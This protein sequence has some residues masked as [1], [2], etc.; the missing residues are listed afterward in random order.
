[1]TKE[2]TNEQAK[3]NSHLQRLSDGL[4]R[5]QQPT[6]AVRRAWSD[7]SEQS[8]DA[9]SLSRSWSN[10]SSLDVSRPVVGKKFSQTWLL[11]FLLGA[12]VFFLLSVGISFYIVT[13]NRNVVSA[14]NVKLELQGSQLVRS[15]EQFNLQ[16]M[17]FNRN[18][19]DLEQVEVVVTYPTGTRR[20]D[21][22][23]KELLTD[24]QQIGALKSG[25]TISRVFPAVLVGEQNSQKE[26]K[27]TVKYH[28]PGSNAEF[29]KEDNYLLTISSS[30]LSLKMN[31]PDEVNAGSE[32]S[33]DIDIVSNAEATLKNLLLTI[34]YPPGF[35]FIEASTKAVA[36]NNLWQLGDLVPG[37][38]RHLSIKGYLA[39]QA[40]DLK[41]FRLQIGPAAIDDD[42]QLAVAYQ[43]AFEMT[44]IKK[45][46]LSISGLVNNQ[47]AEVVT[48]ADG[49]VR[50][51]LNW[52]NNTN[53]E[54][55]DAR[56][57]LTFTGQSLDPTSVKVT[58]AYYQSD[59]NLIYW[60]K[61][62]YPLLA[63]LTPGSSGSTEVEF[64]YRDQLSGKLL[65]NP[66]I[67]WQ[68]KLS[69]WRRPTGSSP[70]SFSSSIE[71]KIR[72]ISK[73]NLSSQVSYQGGVFQPSGP[74]P[75]RANQETTYTISYKLTNS[76]NNLKNVRLMG[77]L[78][79]GVKWLNQVSPVGANISYDDSDRLL[80]WAMD[81]VPA[82][83]GYL[84]E[85]ETV[86]FQ[87]ALTPSLS[88]VGSMANLIEALQFSA[89][90]SFTE[91][92]ISR[93]FGALTTDLR[94]AD[95]SSQ[96][97]GQVLE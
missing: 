78:P 29:K 65:L 45:S 54:I 69:A 67:V 71:K 49:V 33:F 20:S 84:N 63:K 58:D 73:V 86:Y 31:L 47:S 64:S 55:T 11:K 34:A 75:P 51:R 2:Q 8:G 25:V 79:A 1:M 50:L 5:R 76:V 66:E 35:K 24:R 82:G 27:V 72:F 30:P 94:K 91:Q 53:E 16:V 77:R 39:G 15:G 87:L 52:S 21:N 92:N 46:F 42:R 14:S 7:A 62:T 19:Q 89:T 10:N 26:I 22:T 80:T 60:D 61:N 6:T 32:F 3:D 4:Y 70:E 40:E 83:T 36:D 59:N 68:A 85:P 13:N 18:R 97:V 57:E 90:D 95:G 9:I 44:T 23:A 43:D 81:S 56:L 17:V 37:E 38:K 48:V 28:V 41:A 88:Q 74:L 96:N 93:S 12:L